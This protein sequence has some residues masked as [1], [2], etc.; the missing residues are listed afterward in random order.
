MRINYTR[1]G[2]YAKTELHRHSC[3]S[4]HTKP[5]KWNC[6]RLLH[7]RSKIDD[8][9]T[10]LLV[11]YHFYCAFGNNEYSKLSLCRL[12]VSV[13]SECLFL[14]RKR[15]SIVDLRNFSSP[16]FVHFNVSILKQ[17]FQI[18]N[19]TCLFTYSMLEGK[20]SNVHCAMSMDDR[21]PQF[22][23]VFLNMLY[24]Q[25]QKTF[26]ANFERFRIE[27]I[28]FS[29]LFSLYLVPE[30]IKLTTETSYGTSKH[31]HSFNSVK[32]VALK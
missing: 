3:C 24:N 2:S 30:V 22:S 31:I 19:I 29:S 10:H 11:I 28:Y 1:V 26:I 4:L 23:C 32:F 15:G 6:H 21:N 9:I 25:F 27:P 12:I 7:F 20:N 16:T 13:Y 8:E 5:L 17:H 18:C 14:K